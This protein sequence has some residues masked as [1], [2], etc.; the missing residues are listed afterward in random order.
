LEEVSVAVACRGTIGSAAEVLE[1]PGKLPKLR[2]PELEL[3]GA[4]LAAWVNTDAR[5]IELEVSWDLYATDV[6]DCAAA[7]LGRLRELQIRDVRATCGLQ[8]VLRFTTNLRTLQIAMRMQDPAVPLP[9][10]IVTQIAVACRHLIYINITNLA[11]ID[12]GDAV[13][14]AFAALAEHNSNL[15]RLCVSTCDY[16]GDRT[17]LAIAA[18]CPLFRDLE[19][20]HGLRLSDDTLL[21]LVSGCSH[22]IAVY[23]LETVEVTE[24]GLLALADQ[25][26]ACLVLLRLCSSGTIG[27]VTRE[28]LRER[29]PKLRLNLT[30]ENVRWFSA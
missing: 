21:A 3:D 16:I 30:N 14:E 25:R 29:C 12:D 15:Q 2:C 17:V 23:T 10:S 26:P 1:A 22:L 7:V 4:A 18:H 27:E 8:E 28:R 9:L 20:T 24:A 6:T 19:V 5:L 11:G 13:D